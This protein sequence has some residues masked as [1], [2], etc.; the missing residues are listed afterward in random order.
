MEMLF[1]SEY[2]G[3]KRAAHVFKRRERNDY[4]VVCYYNDLDKE[5]YY[6]KT[7]ADA[8]DFAEDW[9]LVADTN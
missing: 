6:F 3:T 4:A 8:D 7:E 5:A 2:I 9:V 1:L